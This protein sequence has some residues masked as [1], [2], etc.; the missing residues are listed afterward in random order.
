MA[1]A[2]LDRLCEL[3]SIIVRR[4]LIVLA[5]LFL[6]FPTRVTVFFVQVVSLRFQIGD[7]GL[8]RDRRDAIVGTY[9]PLK[10][11]QHRCFT[12][13]KTEAPTARCD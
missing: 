6:D 11:D 8:W 3:P 13:Q 2:N 5:L 10:T 9:L 4:P 7:G 1:V 12:P